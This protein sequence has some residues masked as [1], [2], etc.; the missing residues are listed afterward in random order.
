MSITSEIINYGGRATSMCPPKEDTL[1]S[2]GAA[3]AAVPPRAL[4]ASGHRN[5]IV[6]TRAHIS[7]S[8]GKS[9]QCGTSSTR[10]CYKRDSSL[11]AT[12][13]NCQ[14]MPWPLSGNVPLRPTGFISSVKLRDELRCCYRYLYFQQQLLQLSRQYCSTSTN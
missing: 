12:L 13:V 7:V 9:S 6:C 2:P 8:C 4:P 1:R 11:S 5:G 3:G 14:A 10:A